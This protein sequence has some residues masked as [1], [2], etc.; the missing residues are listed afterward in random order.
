MSEFFSTRQTDL[1]EHPFDRSSHRLVQHR[2]AHLAHRPKTPQT[3]FMQTGTAEGSNRE[4]V[5][6]HDQI[7]VS[8][9]T[10]SVT[11]LT[12]PHA[13]FLFPVPMKS[14][15]A[16][17]AIPIRIR[18]ANNVPAG[19]VRQQNLPR[20]LV[21]LF[22]PQNNDSAFV[23]RFR[24]I[25]AHR[26]VILY[27]SVTMNDL[28]LVLRFDRLG[29]VRRL[30]FHALESHEPVRLQ[31]AD[32]ST[33]FAEFVLERIDV[34]QNLATRKETVEH[35]RAGNL[36][37]LTPIDQFEEQLRMVD[38]LDAVLLA[39]I[40][41][42]EATEFER[43]MFLAEAD[44]IDEQIIMG[45]F[46]TFLGM[47]PKPTDVFDHL[48]GMVD[49]NIVEGDHAFPVK[50]EFVRFLEPM[51]S[52]FVE[53][54]DIPIDF[55]EESIETGLIFGVDDLA[56]HSRDGFVSTD[57]QAGEIISEMF[58]LALIGEDS[59]ELFDG[60]FDDAWTLYDSRHV[61]PSVAWGC[62]I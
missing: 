24:H 30:L 11:K 31:V 47:V 26:E 9:L 18:N 54:L 22:V 27:F 12:S 53:L 56:C 55:G 23:V 7:H 33:G 19:L 58:S 51:N 3:P 6:Q 39:L 17:P 29:E 2:T 28:L 45:D 34:I 59:G 4:T 41:F 38:E 61:L 62:P 57:H 40:L 49:E 60:F 5:R 15:R 10:H 20:L 1:L 32:V 36:P 46:V 35:E 13:Q 48:S 50:L 52:L 8:R 21:R 42:G 25:H 44:V 37:F 43:I 14:L 16:R